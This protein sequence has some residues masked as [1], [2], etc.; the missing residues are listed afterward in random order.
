[1]DHNYEFCVFVKP[2]YIL[3]VVG[4]KYIIAKLELGVVYY[5]SNEICVL[6]A[7]W[8]NLCGYSLKK[9]GYSDFRQNII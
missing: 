3:K 8:A 4:I 9:W 7:I 1:M 5:L 2:M 6:F